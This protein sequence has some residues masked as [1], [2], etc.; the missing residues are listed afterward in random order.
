MAS[1]LSRESILKK[2]ASCPL[3]KCC[4]FCMAVRNQSFLSFIA[5]S[6]IKKHMMANYGCTVCIKNTAVRLSCIFTIIRRCIQKSQDNA[7]NTQ[8]ACSSLVSRKGVLRW[9]LVSDCAEW[10]GWMWKHLIVARVF[11]C[12][13]HQP[14]AIF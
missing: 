8:V 13:L 7:H 10:C 5:C 9:C 14:S 11:K 3:K 12:V 4:F 6:D 2:A 1:Q